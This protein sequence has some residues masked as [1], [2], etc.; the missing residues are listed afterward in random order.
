MSG[1]YNS[2][3][4]SSIETEG[5]N[6]P[7]SCLSDFFS[8]LEGR[9]SLLTGILDM[10][11][12]G[13]TL[14][15]VRKPLLVIGLPGIGKTAGIISIIKRFNEMLPEDKKLGFKKCL[16]GQ[17]VVGSMAGIPIIKPD[18]TVVRVQ[19]PDLPDED[20]KDG[21]YGV[22]FLDELSTADEAQVQPALGLCDDSRNIGNYTLPEKWI[23]VA[24]GNGPEAT[25][26]LRLDDMTIT[27]FTV[28]DILYDYKKDWRE[29]AYNTG[30][31]GD[32]IAFLDF[33]PDMVV[34]VESTEQDRA[35]KLC[36][37]P[38]TWERLSI[39]LK[40]RKS[41][42]KPVSQME[43]GSFAGRVV[44]TKAAREFMAFCAYKGKLNYS[45]EDICEG[46][47]RDPE[48]IPQKQIFYLLLEG[49]IS[50][51]E[52]KLLKQDELDDSSYVL[53]ANFVSWFLKFQQF[54]LDCVLAT[55]AELRDHTKLIRSVLQEEDFS[56]FC[57][58]FDDFI[59]NHMDYFLD[60]E[61]LLM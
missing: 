4:F 52:G 1:A 24:A 17:T 16:L 30:I 3:Y 23:V 26:F 20:G 15:E 13:L 54:D 18:G 57:P 33:N 19:V 31:N 43:L 21:E 36:P 47:E 22:F 12:V 59:K 61:D 44:G 41:I 56:A 9:L 40:I 8:D 34:R 48:N 25:N 58:E 5:L 32:I 7:K 38:R 6:T 50:Y 28:Y 45:P 42:K 2:E 46:R 37:N 29:Y 51:V 11:S 55:I 10:E 60:N 35:G 39:E 53:V 49:C 27:R 14:E